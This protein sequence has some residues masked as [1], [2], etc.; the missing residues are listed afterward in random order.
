MGRDTN[1]SV[2]AQLIRRWRRTQ[3]RLTLSDA[4]WRSVVVSEPVLAGLDQAECGR[5]RDLA[6]RFLG[7]RDFVGAGGFEVAR[8]EAVRIAAVA[9]LLVLGLGLDWYRECRTVVVYAS[10]FRVRRDVEDEAGVVHDVTETLTG[11]AWDTG[12]VV[13]SWEDIRAGD[14]ASGY[15]VVIHEFA[16]K[17]DMLDGSSNGRPPLHAGMSAEAWSTAFGSAF[18]DMRGRLDRGEETSLDPYAAESPEEC[19][20]V[21]SETFFTNPALMHAAYPDVYGQLTAFYRQDPLARVRRMHEE[22]NP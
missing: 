15:N 4:E 8:P 17:L 16:H 18:N 12:P 21:F 14:P 5:L 19:F 6:E 22:A 9:V 20:A 1:T 11:E 10:G 2:L 7:S 13:L 3:S